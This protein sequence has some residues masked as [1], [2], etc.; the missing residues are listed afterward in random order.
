MPDLQ[1]AKL[2]GISGIDRVAIAEQVPRG[3]SKVVGAIVEVGTKA[4]MPGERFYVRAILAVKADYVERDIEF[5]SAGALVE[6]LAKI[7]ALPARNEQEADRTIIAVIGKK[8]A[9]V[10][11]IGKS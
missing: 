8:V 11:V 10:C 6:K 1:V 2:A 3:F 9:Y 5:S 7:N 4:V